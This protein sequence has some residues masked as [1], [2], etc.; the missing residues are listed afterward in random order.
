MTE[1]EFYNSSPRSFTNKS[2]GHNIQFRSQ[3][4]MHREIV[5]GLLLPHMTAAD[6]KK[7]LAKL[8]SLPWDNEVQQLGKPKRSG[9]EFWAEI[10]EKEKK[11]KQSKPIQ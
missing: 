4:E 2:Q 9:P 7:P 6:Q 1:A 11:A 5:V 3:M 10:D 8:Y